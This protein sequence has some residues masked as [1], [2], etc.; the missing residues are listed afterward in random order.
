MPDEKVVQKFPVK[1]REISK[2]YIY[3]KIIWNT[4]R[5]F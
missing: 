2:V 3:R 1:S 4:V 5:A